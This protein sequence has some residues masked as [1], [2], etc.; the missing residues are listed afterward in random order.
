M[1][2]LTLVATL[3]GG[4]VWQ[5][6]R[7]IHI[8][9]AQRARVQS[10][11]ILSG[12]LDW[13]RLILGEDKSEVD[14]LGEPWATPLA[15]SRLST[16]L[17]AERGVSNSTASGGEDDG[18]DAFLSGSIVDAQ[19]RW[20]LMNLINP[21]D[22][23]LLKPQVAILER[24]CEAAGTPSDTAAR[25]SSAIQAAFTGPPA[26]G[27]AVMPRSLRDLHWL[28]L[29]RS[30]IEQ[31][32][33]FV[34]VLPKGSKETKVNINTASREVIAAVGGI[35]SGQAQA[36]VE[37]R[38]RSPFSKQGDIGTAMP[39]PAGSSAP[40]QP[41]PASPAVEFDIKSS[42]FEVRGRLRLDDNVLEEVSLVERRGRNS[43]LTIQRERI[44]RTEPAQVA[45][46]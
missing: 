11:W 14:H 38:Q 33:P 41:P 32:E 27:A 23:S 26:A 21:Q 13:A 10:A 30:T 1:V 18:P 4:M 12:A 25:L 6:S 17:Q 19:S 42:F 46:R 3:A 22:G 43:V 37:T 36:I 34:T 31:L 2:I 44:N 8:E 16:F 39:T 29:E 9:G 28:G 20:N 40:G 24:L 35:S 45:L 15:E 7:A 5:F